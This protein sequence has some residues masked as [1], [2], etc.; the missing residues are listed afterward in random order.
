[1]GHF[2]HIS[3][4][5]LRPTPAT[6]Y[7]TFMH[8]SS[9]PRRE[10]SEHLSVFDDGNFVAKWFKNVQSLQDVECSRGT[11]YVEDA[12]DSKLKFLWRN[13]H[14]FLR[15]AGSRFINLLLL[16]LLLILCRLLSPGSF[17]HAKCSTSWWRMGAEPSTYV[18]MCLRTRGR[19]RPLTR[20]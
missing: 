2:P 14:T 1:M 18:Q 15:R 19:R 17:P 20:V 6:F 5:L 12:A 8:I 16:L 11:K 7:D 4:Y 10:E 3:T 13:L 9:P